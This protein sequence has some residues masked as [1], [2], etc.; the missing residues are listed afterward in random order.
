LSR[1]LTEFLHKLARYAKHI[2][3]SGT[4]IEAQE[5]YLSKIS[6]QEV[7]T[8]IFRIYAMPP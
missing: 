4:M 3:V 2:Y 7:R 5:G 1:V 8:A 6:G